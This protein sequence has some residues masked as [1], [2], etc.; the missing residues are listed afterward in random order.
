MKLVL[1]DADDITNFFS[2]CIVA[3]KNSSSP[4]QDTRKEKINFS[5]D[6]YILNIYV[7]PLAKKKKEAFDENTVVPTLKG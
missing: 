7:L 4:K 5:I 2:F 1:K 3:K 6:L